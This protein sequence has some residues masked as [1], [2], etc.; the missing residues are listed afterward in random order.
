MLW[1]LWQEWGCCLNPVTNYVSAKPCTY[2]ESLWLYWQPAWRQGSAH[3]VF[4]AGLKPCCINA[5]L[6]FNIKWV[7]I[8]QGEKA[9][10]KHHS[11]LMGEI[12]AP[13]GILPLTSKQSASHNDSACERRDHRCSGHTV[14][15]HRQVRRPPTWVQQ[16][17]AI[18]YAHM[19]TQWLKIMLLRSLEEA[20]AWSSSLG[21]TTAVPHSSLGVRKPGPADMHPYAV[22]APLWINYLLPQ[23]LS[24]H[25]T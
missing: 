18:K 12:L 2:A 1:L 7:K 19:Q 23:N 25:K 14:A 4:I 9:S 24:F 22:L 10:E 13:M 21:E 5:D 11:N 17:R 8:S 16:D 3:L 15:L 20:T 6:Y